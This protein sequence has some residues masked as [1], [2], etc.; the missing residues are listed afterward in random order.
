MHSIL[1][2]ST[3]KSES[4]GIDRCRPRS[5]YMEVSGIICIK[6]QIRRDTEDNFSCFTIETYGKL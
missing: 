1:T 5:S 2:F 3:V 6:L 4:I